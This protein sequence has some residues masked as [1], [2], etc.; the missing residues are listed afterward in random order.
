[1]TQVTN[2]TT[3]PP[4]STPTPGGGFTY[5]GG[6]V[7]TRFT[8]SPQADIILTFGG[9]DVVA[10]GGGD[11]LV[12]TGGGNDII[13]TNGGNDTVLSGSGNDT[14]AGG[15]G[16]DLIFGGKG[17]DL[18]DGGAGN[19]TVSG[20]RGNDIV[21]GGSGD[22]RV[23][24]GQDNDIVGGG[25]GNDSVYGGKGN[26]TVDG[27]AGN[28]FV[29]G[30]RGSDVL[31]GGA[32]NDTF[33]FASIGG[34]FGVD[35]VT[36]FTPAEDKIRLKSGGAFA[37]LGPTFEAAEFVVVSNFTPGTPGAT[38]NKLIYDPQSGILYFNPG[39]T[40]VA[41]AQLQTGLTITSN[42]FELF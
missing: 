10:S 40:A 13:G 9:D 11:D 20:D 29:T 35:T 6:Q 16:N 24:G 21:L 12:I 33:Y 38:T 19:D 42:N 14:V 28:D 18:L 31:T 30:D 25:D 41:V 5:I 3:P 7:A 8:A 27:G 1:M 22:D 36:D 26:D 23:F 39:T 4:I 34:D 17:A 15:D 37:G 2:P 32:G